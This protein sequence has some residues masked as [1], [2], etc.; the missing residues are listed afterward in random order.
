MS[1][2]IAVL[3]ASDSFSEVWCQLAKFAG[4]TVEVAQAV[5]EIRA[6]Q[7]A[8]GVLVS[9]GGVED[10]AVGLLQELRAARAPEAVVVGVETNYRVVAGILQGGASNYFALPHDLGLCRSWFVD[11]VER[12]VDHQMAKNFAADERQRF[13]FSKIV[14]NS[15]CLQSTLR[16]TARIIPRSNA[17]VLITGETGTGKELIARAIHY[18]SSRAASPF[19]EINCTTLPEHLLEAELFGYEPGAFTDARTAK[20]GLFEVADGG[21]L[22]LDEIGDLSGQLQA[23]LL[24]VIEE[25]RVRRLGSI[26]EVELDL[27]VVAATHVDLPEA[28][29]NGRFRKDLFYRLSVVPVQLPPLRERGN[30]IFTLAE[31]FLDR[32]A[33]E[34]AVH[35]PAI[36][37]DIRRA[38]RTHSWP[39]N[40]RELRNAIERA[41]LL[42]DG[43]L[44]VEDLFPDELA[45]PPPAG[46]IPF[47][48]SMQ[49]MQRAAASAMVDH[50]GGNKSEAAKVL[51]ISRKHLYSLLNMAEVQRD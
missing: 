23:K 34:Y 25:K 48:A 29:R 21:T 47:P 20:P 13:D 27:R 3:A 51:R 4:A 35:R 31:H 28:T 9:A 12:F 43:N 1:A 44:F 19:V 41:V 32:F 18:N 42:G 8:S 14:G 2:R 38:L 24:R 11:R 6:L 10:K 36:T 49:V 15:P 30:D 40:V 39:G 26:R 50:C 22:F 5:G 46:P 37:A 17:T 45:S 7:G 16:R 33:D